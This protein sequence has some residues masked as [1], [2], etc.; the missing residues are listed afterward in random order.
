MH[1]ANR[2][3]A[4]SKRGQQL[5][6]M[7]T[8]YSERP[9]SGPDGSWSVGWGHVGS[10][11]PH[12]RDFV[13]T[14]KQSMMFFWHDTDALAVELLALVEVPLTQNQFD[15][16]MVAAFPTGARMW[17]ETPILQAINAG[18][19]DAAAALIRAMPVSILVKDLFAGLDGGGDAHLHP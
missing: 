4:L 18:E 3:L 13:V 11:F 2:D 12:R 9:E 10:D 17:R 19:F 8:G 16:L 15:A 7:R 14:D 6:K 1:E 5:L